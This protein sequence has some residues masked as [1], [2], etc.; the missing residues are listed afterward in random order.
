FNLAKR[1]LHS[2]EST[3]TRCRP[4]P[5]F[6]LPSRLVDVGSSSCSPRMHITTS[7]QTSVDYIA[8]SHCW[9][10]SQP[11]QLT[12]SNL[13]AMCHGIQ[14]AD[15]PQNFQDA[16]TV[17]RA[18]GVRYLWIDSLCILQDSLDD[19][20][21]ES[22][23]MSC[24]YS[25]AVFVLAAAAGN[26][27]ESGFIASGKRRGRVSIVSN[28][29]SETDLSVR[30]IPKMRDPYGSHFR[31]CEEGSKL[32]TRGW[33]FQ[34]Q[35]LARRILSYSDE[36]MS[37][38]C[39]EDSLCECQVTGS[40]SRLKSMG[41]RRLIS[42]LISVMNLDRETFHAMWTDLV[43]EYTLRQLTYPSDRLTAFSGIA[44]IF[45]SS[46]TSREYLAGVWEDHLRP[47]LVWIVNAESKIYEY[48]IDWHTAPWRD[49]FFL[50]F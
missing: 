13:E 46:P 29:D 31:H 27:C 20:D 8:L 3:H 39:L 24:I 23:Q 16:V 34:E 9:G 12:C 10:E 11:L 48:R 44:S 5:K 35:L 22:K 7:D 40:Q 1:W 26:N 49:I 14:F 17:A 41:V 25:N 33:A 2:C 32:S 43:Q 4:R 37:W 45:Y 19:W 47:G 50:V 6:R 21:F 30:P 18:F 36:E 42:S 28:H 15:L 38:E